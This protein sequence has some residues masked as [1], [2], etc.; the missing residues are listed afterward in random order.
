MS[1]WQRGFPVKGGAYLVYL[2]DGEQCVTFW[3]DGTGKN[4]DTWGDQRPKGWSC[5]TDSRSRV[6][7]WKELDLKPEWVP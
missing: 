4:T 1:D 6:I 5:L 3:N 7:A 2:A